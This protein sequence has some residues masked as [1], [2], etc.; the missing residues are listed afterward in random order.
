MI[1]GDSIIK[2]VLII[3]NN[4]LVY[5]K[6]DK[7][8][9]MDYLEGGY[10]DVLYSAR[11]RIH[12]GSKLLTHPLMG[13]VKPNE[14][15]YRTIIIDETEGD[16]DFDSLTIIEGSINTAKKFPLLNTQLNERIRYDFQT[17]DLKLIESALLSLEV[18]GGHN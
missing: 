13:S 1:W 4:S 8:I 11:D 6:Y 12:K 14:T 9:K 18:I 17:I 10:M 5:D 7:S 16:L 3:T 2:D 15:P